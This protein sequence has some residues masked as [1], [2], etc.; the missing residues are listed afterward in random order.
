MRE[1]PTEKNDKKKRKRAKKKRRPLKLGGPALKYKTEKK[2][3]ASKEKTCKHTRKEKKQVN[4]S[5]QKK[6]NAWKATERG[7][8]HMRDKS[9][10]INK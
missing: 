9:K 4:K 2:R 10:K 7:G 6:R 5:E 3:Q 8:R 1:K